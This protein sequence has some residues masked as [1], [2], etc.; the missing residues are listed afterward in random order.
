M[1]LGERKSVL[2]KGHD[3]TEGARCAWRPMTETSIMRGWRPIVWYGGHVVEDEVGEEILSG[4][5]Y[6]KARRCDGG[7]NDDRGFW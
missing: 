6:H 3:G 5:K 2:K 4:R 1:G 7:L